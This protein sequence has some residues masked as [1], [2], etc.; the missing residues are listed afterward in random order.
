MDLAGPIEKLEATAYT[1][2]TEEPECDGTFE[3]ESTTLILVEIQSGRHVGTGFS[4]GSEASIPLIRRTM[5]PE[6]VG[7]DVLELPRIWQAMMRASRN[8]GRPGLGLEFKR[9]DA[10]PYK[11][12]GA[13]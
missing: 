6:V 12:R 10:E 11:V 13:R 2:P 3:W 8:I 5:A 9:S 1:V 4:Y 7:A